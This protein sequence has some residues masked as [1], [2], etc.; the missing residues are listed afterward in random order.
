MWVSK[1]KYMWG[2]IASFQV[3]TGAALIEQAPWLIPAPYILIQHILPAPQ[4]DCL[5]DFVIFLS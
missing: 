1:A 5:K 2:N 3:S 4:S